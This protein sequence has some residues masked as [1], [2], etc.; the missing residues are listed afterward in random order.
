MSDNSLFNENTPNETPS[1]DQ[2]TTLFTVGDRGYDVDSAKT[3]IEHAETFINTLKTE[4]SQMEEQNRIFQ[5]ENARLQAQLEQAAKLEDALSMFNKETTNEPQTQPVETPSLDVEAL[6]A[7]LTQEVLAEVQAK[8][9][10]KVQGTNF[11]T[12]M[13]AAQKAFG[14]DMAAKLQERGAQLGMTP[15]AIDNLAKTQPAVFNELF[16]PKAPANSA[17]PDGM[18]SGPA[19]QSANLDSVIDNWG[20]REK[21]WS[22]QSKAQSLRAMEKEVAKLI[23]EGKIDPHSKKL[24]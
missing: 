17:S 23:K 5:Q 3:K 1:A 9:A 7:A 16:I 12:S 6:K 13:S 8:E 11:E 15:Q 19:E 24:F 18:F 14:A 10:A 22:S 20:D 21:F 4:K 2:P